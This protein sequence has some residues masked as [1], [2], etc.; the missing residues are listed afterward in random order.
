MAQWGA[1]PTSCLYG[2]ASCSRDGCR[3]LMPVFAVEHMQPARAGVGGTSRLTSGAGDSTWLVR[4]G[5]GN[6]DR[7]E[8]RAHC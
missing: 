7:G 4:I 8:N 2:G 6:H 5:S 3:Q 1:A